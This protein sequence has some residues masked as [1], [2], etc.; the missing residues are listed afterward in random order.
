MTYMR[1][2]SLIIPSSAYLTVRGP[3]ILCNS[4]LLW[5]KKLRNWWEAAYTD[6]NPNKSPPNSNAKAPRARTNQQD[7]KQA[8]PANPHRHS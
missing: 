3:T 1:D 6:G 2:I 7:I 4:S 8:H 5:S